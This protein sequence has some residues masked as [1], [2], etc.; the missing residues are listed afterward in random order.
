MSLCFWVLHFLSDLCG[1]EGAYA[2]IGQDGF[3][4]SDLCGRE[5]PLLIHC[6]KL[7]FL[8]D[9]CGREELV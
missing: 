9:L 1:R 6:P 2:V 5:V 7:H 3:F 8:S 4:L